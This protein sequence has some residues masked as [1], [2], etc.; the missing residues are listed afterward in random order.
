MTNVIPKRQA[1]TSVSDKHLGIGH[2]TPERPD[3]SDAAF[4]MMRSY[5][6]QVI[7]AQIPAFKNAATR[8]RRTYMTTRSPI[9]QSFQDAKRHD[10]SGA[11]GQRHCRQRRCWREARVL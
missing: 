4:P 5:V 7:V 2:A 3:E 6:E 8:S 1:R 9:L 11:C 10:A